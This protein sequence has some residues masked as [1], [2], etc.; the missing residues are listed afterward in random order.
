MTRSMRMPLARARDPFWDLDGDGA[1][2]VRRKRVA[3]SVGILAVA[4]VLLLFVWG[5]PGVRAASTGV[6]L[7]QWASK[8]VAWQNGNLNGNNSRYPEGGIVP[9]RLAIE[10]LS[11][12]SHS[13]HINYDFTASGHK[14]YDFLATW[15]VTN[16]RARCCAERA[17]A[18][19]RCA[20]RLPGLVVF[21]FPPTATRRTASPSTAP[22]LLRG[23]APADDLRRHDHLDQRPGPHRLAR[24]QQHGRLPREVQVDAA[25]RSCWRGAA[26]SPSRRT[27]TRR[28]AARRRRRRWSRA[29]RGTCGRCSST[30]SG[31]KNQDRSIQ[32]SAIVGELPPF[33]LAPP[34]PT[35]RP[36]NPPAAPPPP[37]SKARPAT[38][39][40]PTPRPVAAARTRGRPTARVASRP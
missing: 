9:F 4:V 26:T 13:I 7:D 31:N 20:P 21:A 27:G 14:A 22:R 40:P 8:D 3:V 33:A 1:R 17:A 28:A 25:R 15:N 12:G 29:R 38:R 11:A 19:R 23:A 36:T 6:N 35:P 37:R 39:R 5:V 2:R 32:P 34:T 10:G 18:S 16:A 30:A 24:R